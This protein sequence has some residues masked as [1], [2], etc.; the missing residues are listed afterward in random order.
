[1]NKINGF[2]LVESIVSL[3]L[4]SLV[5]SFLLPISM[6][7]FQKLDQQKET[8]QLYQQIF[9]HSELLR[10]RSVP[11]LFNDGQVK[12]FYYQGGVQI[13]AKK[14]KTEKCTL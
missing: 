8:S 4:F 11:I 1:M 7:I 10:Y 9:E 13:C 2:S 14:N 5:C 12:S 3:L 6:T